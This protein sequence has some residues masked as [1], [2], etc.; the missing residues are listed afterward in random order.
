MSHVI[1]IDGEVESEISIF[2]RNVQYGD[3]LFETCVA[4]DNKV[5]F[6]DNHFA[7]L[8]N[9]CER[10]NIK[11]IA[12][13]VWLEDIKK[14]ISLS[15][16]KNCIAKL[17]LSRGN[18]LRGYSYVK[19]IEPVRVVIISQMSQYKIKEN[20]SLEFAIS[21]FHSNPNL[22]G[23]KHCNRLEQIMARTNMLADEAIMLDENQ[24]VIS[25]T[26]GNIYFIFG[27]KLVT[28]KLE[29]CG[30]IG[31]RRSIILELSRLINLEVKE[32]DIS[33]KQLEKAN[34]VFVSNSLIGIQPV[35]SIGEYYQKNNPLTEKIRA[36]YTSIT[37]DIKSWTCL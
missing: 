20:Y 35:T 4:K 10:L 36:A 18:S 6:W 26:Q 19:D 8:N 29:R 34:E 7:R 24:S 37:Q 30:V 16:E 13:S 9:G 31:S 17:I 14:A 33:I 12:S 23:I 27:K 15:S 21:G 22:A 25:V 3:G 5:L 2:N 28:P 32:D 1:L 11:K